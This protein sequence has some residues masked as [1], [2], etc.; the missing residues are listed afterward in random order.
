MMMM[1]TAVLGRLPVQSHTHA[2]RS[3]QPYPLVSQPPSGTFGRTEAFGLEPDS[4]QPARLS[5]FLSPQSRALPPP[6]PVLQLLDPPEVALLQHW[7]LAPPHY[8]CGSMGVRFHQLSPVTVGWAGRGSGCIIHGTPLT[9]HASALH[10]ADS[11]LRVC[12]AI[13]AFC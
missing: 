11:L 3:H 2:L 6:E 8:L 5:V 12:G 10:T 9:S 13:Q 1:G 7:L 4:R